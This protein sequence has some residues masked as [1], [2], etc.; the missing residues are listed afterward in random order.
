MTKTGW[1]IEM[2]M[3]LLNRVWLW[4]LLVIY[5]DSERTID[6]SIPQIRSALR[7]MG[8]DGGFD[9]PNDENRFDN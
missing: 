2:M 7:R 5:W 1:I 9:K 6:W 3:W 4:F 8:E